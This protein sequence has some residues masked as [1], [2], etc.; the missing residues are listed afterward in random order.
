MEDTD[1]DESSSLDSKSLQNII[2]PFIFM[3]MSSVV[4]LIYKFISFCFCKIKQVEMVSNENGI[5]TF[6]TDYDENEKILNNDNNSNENRKSIQ[7]T[8]TIQ[9]IIKISLFCF[10]L[11]FFTVCNEIFSIFNCLEDQFDKR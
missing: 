4:Y 11:L 1:F 10:Y 2:F 5:L 9:T 6:Q 7:R 8:T 3:L